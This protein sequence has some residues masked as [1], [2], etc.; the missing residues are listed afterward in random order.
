[1]LQGETIALVAQWSKHYPAFAL[2]HIKNQPSV[3][4]QLI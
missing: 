4:R 1:M 2:M 3:I